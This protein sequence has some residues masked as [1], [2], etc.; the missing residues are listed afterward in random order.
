MRVT[1]EDRMD[2]DF[3]NALAKVLHFAANHPDAAGDDELQDAISFLQ[4]N[5]LAEGVEFVDE[6]EANDPDVKIGKDIP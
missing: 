4:D 5:L 2:Q 3:I 1:Q 6:D